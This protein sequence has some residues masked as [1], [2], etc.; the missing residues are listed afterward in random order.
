MIPRPHHLAALVGAL[1]RSPVV[2]LLGPRQCGKT[3][4]ARRLAEERPCE[5]FDLEHPV[6]S[7]RL[8]SPLLTLAGLRGTVVLDEI[9]RRPELF[10]VLRVLADRPGVP[11]RFVVLGSASPDLVRGAAETL[12]GRVAF[13]D[14][15]GFDLSEVGAER[16]AGLWHRGRFPRAFLAP[17]DGAAFAWCNDF[18]RTFLE[19]DIPQLGIRTPAR[20]LRRFWTM[21]AHYHGQTWNA[22]ELARAL[23]T[24]EPTA[25]RYVDLLSGAYVVRQLQPWHANVAK[26]Q[27]KA[28]KVYVRDTGLLHALL[29]L[30]THSDRVGHPKVGASW[31]GF[32]VEEIIAATRSRDIY[33]WAT[34][35]GAE[36]DLLLFRHG[37]ATGF[38]MKHTDAPRT[39]KS[40]RVALADLALDHLHVVYPGERTYPLDERITATSILDLHA[41]LDARAAC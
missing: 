31:E 37:R 39:T 25:R 4:L 17:S 28:P 20:T 40:M 36:L 29:G 27:V 21:L 11:A 1:E 5:V 32:V 2:A 3:T 6:D 13:V 10:E 14:L 33:Y 22:A 12:A 34:H 9:Q 19:R 24:S 16:F 41:L 35:G 8:E 15:G 18:V 23:G 26:R 38:E 7:R 30:E